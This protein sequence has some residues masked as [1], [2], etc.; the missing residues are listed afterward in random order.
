[1]AENAAPIRLEIDASQAIALYRKSAVEADK[2]MREFLQKASKLVALDQKD[3]AKKRLGI[4]QA[5]SRMKTR[6]P[7]R[8][9]GLYKASIRADIDPSR[10]QSSI[11][12]DVPYGEWVD[13]G[14][15]GKR[16]PESHRGGTFIG[17][18]IV[19]RSGRTSEE[20]VRK[21]FARIFTRALRGA[22]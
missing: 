4:E 6:D 14:V 17:H 8:P 21:M 16:I 19:E 9:K 12:P 13:R 15:K 20:P 10:K 11:G 5:E 3:D 22:G 7:S 1:M 2:A 18:R